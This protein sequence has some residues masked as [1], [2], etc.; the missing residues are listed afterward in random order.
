MSCNIIRRMEPYS[1]GS[2]SV[3]LTVSNRFHFSGFQLS[4]FPAPW[5]L[6]L[7]RRDIWLK[8]KLLLYLTC[9]RCWNLL[10][11]HSTLPGYLDSYNVLFVFYSF[12]MTT[13]C[14]R[15]ASALPVLTVHVRSTA[16]TFPRD[17]SCCTLLPS[18]R[19]RSYKCWMA[20]HFHI[21]VLAFP[22]IKQNALPCKERHTA[23]MLPFPALDAWPCL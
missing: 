14:T 10:V 23:T 8:A 3:L 17:S 2:A 21:S 16:C 5:C 15:Q 13:S 12:C 6:L 19:G 9:T 7:I 4:A 11:L 18:F 20:G 22:I 1:V